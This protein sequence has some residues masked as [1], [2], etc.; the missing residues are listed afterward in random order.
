V[1][2]GISASLSSYLVG[3]IAKFTGRMA[4][5]LSDMLLSMCLHSFILLFDIKKD[6]FM[7]IYILAVFYGLFEAIYQTQINGITISNLL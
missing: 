7:I 3:F 5:I 4:L 2:Y 6:H 1:V